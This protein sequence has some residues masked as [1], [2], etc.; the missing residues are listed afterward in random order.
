MG[1][2]YNPLCF[3]AVSFDFYPGFEDE[4]GA[5]D[6]G[7]KIHVFAGIGLQDSWDGACET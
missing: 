6:S 5:M 3:L 4:K 7:F 2:F 1:F